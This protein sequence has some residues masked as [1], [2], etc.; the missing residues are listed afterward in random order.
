M[1]TSSTSQSHEKLHSAFTILRHEDADAVDNFVTTLNKLDV[2]TKPLKSAKL[3]DHMFMPINITPTGQ[4][5][6]GVD[7]V[8]TALQDSVSIQRNKPRLHEVCRT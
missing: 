8:L 5:T 7:L 6:V 2:T 3:S 1:T 4:D